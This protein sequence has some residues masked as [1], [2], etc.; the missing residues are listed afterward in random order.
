[1]RVIRAAAVLAVAIV[2]AVTLLAQGAAGMGLETSGSGGG[3]AVGQTG[4]NDP[5]DRVSTET[6]FGW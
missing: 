2:L 1:M 4:Y 3:P 5:G 6:H